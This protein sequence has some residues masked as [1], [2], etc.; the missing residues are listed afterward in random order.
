MCYIGALSI[1]Q[2]WS[3]LKRLSQAAL[4]QKPE[5]AERLPPNCWLPQEDP[6]TRADGCGPKAL[7]TLCCNRSF[8]DKWHRRRY[9]FWQRIFQESSLIFDLHNLS[10]KLSLN[11]TWNLM[12]FVILVIFLQVVLPNY[13]YYV[14]QSHKWN[15]SKLLFNIFRIQVFSLNSIRFFN[16]STE[17]EAFH[18]IRCQMSRKK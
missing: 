3:C 14:E 16:P 7:G 18:K 1:L 2:L 11:W 6:L 9:F 17:R 10:T 15:H 13:S 12:W 8:P 4:R 5:D